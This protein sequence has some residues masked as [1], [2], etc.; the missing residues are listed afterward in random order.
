MKPIVRSLT[1]TQKDFSRAA[2]E[3]GCDIAAIKAVCQVEAPKGGFTE[4]NLP[5][6]LFEG[7]WFHKYTN[8]KYDGETVKVGNT[9]QGYRELSI[10]YPKWT[11]KHYGKNQIEE[12]LRLDYASNLD[13]TS[14]LM[15][16][17]WGRFQIMGF[18]FAICGFKTIQKFI[19]D[20]YN[21]EGKQL[22]AFVRYIKSTGLD[23][24]LKA[25]LW[26]EFA[27]KYNGPLYKR[28]RYSERL[29]KEYWRFK[30]WN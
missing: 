19:N 23:D 7:H 10:S 27:Y 30:K 11:R 28:N 12:K 15:S 22:D 4:G 13:R 14:A 6:T 17:S 21:S 2:I 5:I 8:G 3:I 24:E 18:N 29:E 26:E 20:M 1:L 16:A 9:K 25:C